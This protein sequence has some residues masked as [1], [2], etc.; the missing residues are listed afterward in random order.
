MARRGISSGK[1]KA[2]AH[3]LVA[4]RDQ[5]QFPGMIMTLMVSRPATLAALD[6]AL[7][8]DQLVVVLLQKDGSVETPSIDDLF[9]VGVLSEVLHVVPLP[10]GSSRAVL[11]GLSRVCANSLEAG[12][13]GYTILDE[14]VG[15]P[16][17]TLAARRIVTESFANL[18]ANHRL[19]PPESMDSVAAAQ[20]DSALADSIA[21]FLPC[22]APD[23]QAILAE[24]NVALRMTNLLRLAKQEESLITIEQEIRDQVD[25][26][27]GRAQRQF[28]LKEQLRAIQTELGG[29]GQSE[30][31]RFEILLTD[32]PTAAKNAASTELRKLRT[33]EPDSAE[34]QTSR[35][36]LDTLFS[37]PW[38]ATAAQEINLKSAQNALEKNHFGLD[39]VKERMIEFLAVHKLNGGRQGGVLCFV[40]PP[41][42]GKTSVAHTIA[43]VLGRPA[44]NIALGGLKDEAEIRGHRRTYVGARMGKIMTALR[45]A[46]EKNPVCILD[47]ID[48]MHDGAQGDPASAL[49][50]VLDAEQN[51]AFVDHYLEI[52]F[53]LSEVLFIATANLLDRLPSALLD[54]LEIIEFS[55]YSESERKEIAKR[56]ILPSTALSSG[57]EGIMPPLT[58]EATRLL[59]SAYSREAGVRGLSR[60]CKRLARKLA[61][62]KAT[63]Q[64][65]PA[66]IDEHELVRLLG[67]APVDNHVSHQPQVGTAHGLVVTGYGGDIMQVEVGLARPL[68]PEPKLT[69][70]GALGPVMQESVQTALTFVR[71]QLDS[72]QIDSR[73]DV[74]L[75]LPQAAIPK[76]GPSAGLT[77]ALALFSAFTGRPASGTVA[78][79]GEITLRGQVL[80]VGGLREKILAAKRFGYTTVLYPAPLQAEVERMSEEVRDGISLTPIERFEQ[81]LEHAFD[82]AQTV[83]I[84]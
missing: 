10:D 32:L 51:R 9:S 40:G 12:K 11:R 26:E 62:L 4:V 14:E 61:T 67:P 75:H 79:T 57:L 29:E 69:L 5:V 54:R 65:L 1:A 33:A 23:K 21:F 77:I 68:G 63:D 15:D 28:F 30:S 39:A 38:S 83:S 41:G 59:A 78:M 52:P 47:E 64:P 66:I 42:V 74:H 49:L 16:L 2:T 17:S 73:F 22:S 58:E 81:A 3:P 6:A 44:V 24:P 31:D 70:T 37:L 13:I 25:S 76:D 34:A 53:D 43:E 35:T 48:K 80:P 72:K 50:E 7:A 36:Y 46:G 8:G 45:T 20:S 55:G 56:H 19:V 71:S 27:I 60:E 18:A 84:L 82:Y